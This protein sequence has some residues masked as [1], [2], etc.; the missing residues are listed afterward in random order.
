[1]EKQSLSAWINAIAYENV[2]NYEHAEALN[3]S[4]M[5]FWNAALH[6]TDLFYDRGIFVHFIGFFIYWV[7]N[8]ATVTINEFVFWGL[9]NI[10]NWLIYLV[11]FKNS[12]ILKI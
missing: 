9:Q 1:M 3:P 2:V 5:V 10:K 7:I 8:I 11:S 6:I 4:Q 12:K